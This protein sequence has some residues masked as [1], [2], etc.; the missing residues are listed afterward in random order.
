[1]IRN[2]DTV[3]AEV[4]ALRAMLR[5][6]RKRKELAMYEDISIAVAAIGLIGSICSIAAYAE[7]RVDKYRLK[8]REK[9]MTRKE[10]DREG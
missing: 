10:R 6:P 7:Y 4:L 8:R 3:E 9:K 5:K 1:M 2:S